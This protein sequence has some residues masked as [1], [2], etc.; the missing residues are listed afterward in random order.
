MSGERMATIQF[1]QDAIDRG[2]PT[3]E[4]IHKS[5]ADLPLEM[6]LGGRGRGKPGRVNRRSR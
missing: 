1:T 4:E 3:V 5:I 6:T 2:A